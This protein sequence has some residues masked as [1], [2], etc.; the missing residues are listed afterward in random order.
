MLSNPPEESP[1]A[2]VFFN[3]LSTFCGGLFPRKNFYFFSISANKKLTK[4][5]KQKNTKKFSFLKK[6]IIYLK[7]SFFPIFL[8]DKGPKWYKVDAKGK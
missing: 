4:N 5:Q 7:N 2:L 8:L 6:G 1:S 3:S